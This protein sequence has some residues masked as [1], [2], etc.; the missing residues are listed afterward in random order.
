MDDGSTKPIE[1]VKI[2]DKVLATDPTSGRRRIETATAESVGEGTKPL[3]DVTS[4]V[5][6]C[7]SIAELS[8]VQNQCRQ[9]GER[10]VRKRASARAVALGWWAR[11]WPARIRVLGAVPPR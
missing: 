2:G 10:S 9:C 3:V 6:E 7:V 8:T 5:G 4:D 11:M 1:E